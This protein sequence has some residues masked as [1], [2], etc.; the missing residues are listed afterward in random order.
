MDTGW[1]GQGREGEKE[2]EGKVE[3]RSFLPWM[4]P[5]APSPSTL[6]NPLISY[7]LKMRD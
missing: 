7:R 2:R 4:S 3:T 1:M 5:R 6:A